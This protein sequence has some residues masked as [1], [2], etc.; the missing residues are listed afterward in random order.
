MS[1]DGGNKTKLITHY[2]N[3]AN[4]IPQILFNLQNNFIATATHYLH[5]ASHTIYCLHFAFIL[6]HYSHY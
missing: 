3:N 1:C 2:V 6:H 5:Y 4:Y